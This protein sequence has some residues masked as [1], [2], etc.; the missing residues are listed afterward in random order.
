MNVIYFNLILTKVLYQNQQ[1]VKYTCFNDLKV[2]N[3]FKKIKEEWD[4]KITKDQKDL[5]NKNKEV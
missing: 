3:Q 2:M 4:I 1:I 5:Q